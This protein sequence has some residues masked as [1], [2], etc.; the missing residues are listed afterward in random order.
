MV[1]LTGAGLVVTDLKEPVPAAAGRKR[2]HRLPLFLWLKAR[3][4]PA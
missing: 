4:F 3:P 1:A 2:W